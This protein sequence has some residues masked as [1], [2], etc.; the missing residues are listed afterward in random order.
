MCSSKQHLKKGR[1]DKKGK[2][3]NCWS[4]IART[5]LGSTPNLSGQNPTCA[6][7]C[8]Q[9]HK[10]PPC[11]IL[12][13]PMYKLSFFPDKSTTNPLLIK[14]LTTTLYF[15]H[16]VNNA[17]REQTSCESWRACDSRNP[18][19]QCSPC[20]CHEESWIGI[21]DWTI[22]INININTINGG[23][24]RWRWW[25]RRR[26]RKRKRKRKANKSCQA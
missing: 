19:S 6:F 23:G 18:C 21:V 13:C 10:K 14:T 16:Y 4:C 15:N 8:V 22:N 9:G 12:K 1:K 17:R 20:S 24:W 11:R 7:K 25:W 2:T 3:N 5:C 26:R